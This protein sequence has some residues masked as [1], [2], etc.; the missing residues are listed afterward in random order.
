VVAAL[1]AV[2]PA[3][4]SERVVT[5]LGAPSPVRAWAGIA[6]FSVLDPATATFRLAVSRQGGPPRPLPVR[7]RAAAFDADIGPGASGAPEIVFS[8]CADQ[9]PGLQRGCRLFR[10]SLRTRRVH[11]IPTATPPGRS[12]ISPSIWGRTLAWVDVRDGERFPRP[13]VLV[14][15][16][17]NARPRRLDVVPR[18]R[19]FPS[20]GCRPTRDAR[21]AALDV[22]GSRVAVGSVYVVS[23]QIEEVL[24]LASP[25]RA[26][27]RVARHGIGLM[28][29]EVRLHRPRIRGWRAALGPDLRRV[30]P[31]HPAGCVPLRPR[32][33]PL[34]LRAVPLPPHR[35]RPER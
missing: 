14:A 3:A 23:G 18:A 31:E 25:G 17:G 12:A 34:C 4:R 10:F 6:V 13:S 7:P 2:P 27:R 8:R 21:V 16:P 1:L 26:V 19:C 15:G 5:D 32:D 30:R 9:R 33:R 22:W 20:G 28:G 29:G 35:L 11:R 24:E